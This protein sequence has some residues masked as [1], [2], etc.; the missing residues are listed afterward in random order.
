MQVIAILSENAGAQCSTSPKH[1]SLRGKCKRIYDRLIYVFGSA[2]IDILRDLGPKLAACESGEKCVDPPRQ[3][4]Y[5][6]ASHVVHVLSRHLILYIPI[7]IACRQKKLSPRGPS[8]SARSRTVNP[9][10]VFE[11]QVSRNVQA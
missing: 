10:S 9:P 3:V 6:K 8:F 5:N 7:Y 1:A 2:E 11:G 4:L